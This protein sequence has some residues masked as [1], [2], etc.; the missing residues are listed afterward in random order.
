M[1][2]AERMTDAERAERMQRIEDVYVR[3]VAE[4]FV[5]EH[6]EYDVEGLLNLPTFVSAMRAR[7]QYETFNQQ[8][9]RECRSDD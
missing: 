9:R 7:L 5:K 1:T 3:W 8:A 6:P 4:Q 2:K